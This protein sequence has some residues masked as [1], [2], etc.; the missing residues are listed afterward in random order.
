MLV[1]FNVK[2]FLSFKEEEEFNCLPGKATRLGFH[3]VK[4]I[5]FEVLKLSAVYG[6]N[7]SGKSNLINA[8]N[9]LKV[10]ILLGEI[11]N[12]LEGKKFK[13]SDQN[14]KE[15]I[16]FSIEFIHKNK[17]F[18]YQISVGNNQI[19]EE[20][21]NCSKEGVEIFSFK[22]EFIEEKIKITFSDNLNSNPNNQILFGIIEKNLLQPH[23]LLI[24]FLNQLPGNEFSLEIAEAKEWFV[25]KLVILFPETKTNI[26]VQKLDENPGFKLFVDHLIP[27]LNTG[28]TKTKIEK[29]DLKDLKPE[30]LSAD[31]QEVFDHLQSNPSSFVKK[32]IENGLD[33]LV[34]VN[35]GGKVFEKRLF[36][37]SAN[38][39]GEGVLFKFSEQSDGTKRLIEYLPA[40]YSL[41][42]EECTF[43]IDEIE[44]SIHPLLIK[45]LVSKFS[46]SKES[47][48][49][50]IFTTHET[51][52]LNQD[53]FR[54][55]EIWFT[56]KDQF[57]I[58]RIYS[59]SE[60]K[61]HNTIDIQKGYLNGRYGGVPFLGEL[62][63]LDWNEDDERER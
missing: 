23:Q 52:L 45:E 44:R 51:L 7:A 5:G 26:L 62:T 1:S 32:S 55:D 16:E 24:S 33:E 42:N 53:F 11:G 10:L 9:T 14:Q 49:Q 18:Y 4:K 19:Q 25:Q 3:K 12:I 30:L 6:A 59:L 38:D 13:L 48:G 17:L 27:V 50:L 61:E 2:N 63:S 35:E 54:T 43:I 57:G 34:I 47:K 20:N 40:F 56:E 39:K 60:F 29:Q 15:W 31:Y 46:L 37:E 21:F 41:Q 8:I 22:R 36:F 28:I 58:S